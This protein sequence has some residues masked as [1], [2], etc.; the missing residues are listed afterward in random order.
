V[1]TKGSWLI[2][3][4]TQ[5]STNNPVLI[6]ATL[7]A[8]ERFILSHLSWGSREVSCTWSWEASMNFSTICG[9]LPKVHP[10]LCRDCHPFNKSVRKQ[11]LCTEDCDMAFTQLKTRLCSSSL[12]QPFLVQTD[13]YDGCASSTKSAWWE[14]RGALS[15]I[16]HSETA[17]TRRA[18]WNGRKGM[19]GDLAHFASIPSVLA[20]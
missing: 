10:K 13:A 14:W 19:S 2:Y 11:V 6:W 7:W 20:R 8:V 5:D 12:W 1:C 16:I 3:L 17:A 4:A 15:A 9:V 18:I